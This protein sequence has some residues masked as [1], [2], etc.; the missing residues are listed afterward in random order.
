MLCS[1]VKRGVDLAETRSGVGTEH[2]WPPPKREPRRTGPSRSSWEVP[3]PASQ[4]GGHPYLG[5]PRHVVCIGLITT[6]RLTRTELLGEF[7]NPPPPAAY[8]SAPISTAWPG[9]FV[10]C[11]L[12][13]FLTASI[14][15]VPRILDAE[16]AAAT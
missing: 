6:G 11:S 15:Q 1:R 12:R 9:C 3:D 7:R 8:P 13:A 16:P 5:R 2:V 4:G 10:R 14:A